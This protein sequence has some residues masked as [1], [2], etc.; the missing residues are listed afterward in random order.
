MP[1]PSHLNKNPRYLDFRAARR[2]PE[3]HAWPGL[4]DHPVVDGG[5]PGPDAVPVV[6]LGAADPAPAAA[7]A[8]AR[9]AEQWG[10]FLLTGHG[11]PADLLARVEDRIATMFAL[12]ADDKMRAVR[13]PGDACGYGSP[14]IS[15]FFS[16]CM[17][18]EGYTFSPA[19]LRADLRKLWPKAGDDY[20]SFWYVALRA[21]VR[22][23]LPTAAT[24]YATH[25][26]VRA[27]ASYLLRFAPLARLA[28]HMHVRP[29]RYSRSHA[30][31][32]ARTSTDMIHH[33]RVVPPSKAMHACNHA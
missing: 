1:T 20:T 16:K 27:L 32:H 31:T 3:S 23:H 21:C 11:V 24:P 6:D 10:A 19:S 5:A 18:S 15:S 14:P 26:Y 13:G 28:M 4:H 30:R 33:R 29:Y 25:A 2:V 7:A 17:W 22:A 8:V 9:A 12:P